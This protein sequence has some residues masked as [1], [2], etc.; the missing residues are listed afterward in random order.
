MKVTFISHSDRIGGAAV[1]TTRLMQ[2]L[3]RN[4]I[5]ARMVVYTKVSD[6]PYVTPI[7]TRFERGFKFMAERGRIAL[8][9]GMSRADLFKVSIA[10]TGMRLH[11]HPWVRE[12]DVIVLTWVN[13][14]LLSLRGIERLGRL[15]K[16]LVWI[17]HDM[18]C[19]TGICHHAYECDGYRQACGSCRFL[20]VG[21]ANDLSHKTHQRKASLYAGTP[22]TFVA[23]SHWLADCA[24]SST[25][26]ADA[27]LRV[28]PNAFPV[29]TFPITPGRMAGAI[30]LPPNRD[31]ILMG[32][33]RLDD[34]IKGMPVAVEALNWIFDNRPDVVRSAQVVF[35]GDVRDRTLIDS[36]RFPHIY[37]GRIDDPHMLRDLYA[38]ARV[39]ISA[40]HYET[41]PGTLIEGQ[42][43]GAL[44]V[45]FGRGGQ[46]DIITHL[47]DGYIADY[48]DPV[49][50]AEGIIWALKQNVD[51]KEL[52][53][54]VARRFDANVVAKRYV[55]LF[56]ELLDRP[57]D[58]SKA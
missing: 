32:A 7:G 1:V 50:L 49:S 40:S 17:M 28:I 56:T 6:D 29:D 15:G 2:A 36:L 52:H 33:A 12:A 37:I 11:R 58:T 10:N 51:R 55:D 14:G 41:L 16:P 4:G 46:S 5:D 44:P 21:T 39:V 23:V 34:P 19:L 18:W 13:Q 54:S 47:K 45:S 27:D 30:A 26:L 22:I 9:N 38:S 20:G 3:R 31:V 57:R 43:A 24:R 35:F 48:A 42:A 25:L 8:S 53:D